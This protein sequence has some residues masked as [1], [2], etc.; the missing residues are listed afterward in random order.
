MSLGAQSVTL[1]QGGSIGRVGATI[2]RTGTAGS[3]TLSVNGLP[4]GASATFVQPG[5]GSSGTIALNPGTAAA[6]TY[7]LTVQASDGTYSGSASL[8]LILN[9]G[10]A[11]QLPGPFAW[12]STGPLISEISDATHSLVSVKDPTV[13]YY[14]NRWHVYATTADSAGNW[15]ME[16][17]NFTDWSQAAAA[18]PYYIDANPGLR[19]YHC[20]PEVFYFTPQSKWYLIYQSQQPQYSTADDLSQPGT[21]TA[22]QNFFA[23][24]PATVN[25]WID[26]WMICDST[27][28][29][30]FFSGDDGRWYRSQTS[31]ANFPNGF[32][33]PLVI[34]E[35]ANRADL[36]EASNVYYLKGLN[37]YLAIIEC[38]G[39]TSGQRYFRAFI[40]DRLDGDWTP[41]A[42]ANSWATPFAGINNVSFDSG[43]SAWTTDISHGEMLRDGYDQTL[44]IDPAN[45]QFLY[46]GVNPAA[47]GQ[48]YA[49]LPWQLGII[50][51]VTGA[52]AH[53]SHGLPVPPGGGVPKPSGAAGG[54]KVLDW[55]GFKAAVTYTYDDALPSQIAAYPQ[56]QA[57]GARMTFFLTCG[58]D[59]N[60]P[61]WTQAA[62][63][64]HELGNHTVHHCH[65]DGTGCANYA[66]SLEAEYDLCTDHIKQTYGVSNVWTTAAPFGDTGYDAVAA[67]RF[68]LNRGVWGGQVAPNDNSDPYNLPIHGV[69]EGETAGAFNSYID[70]ARAAGHWLIFMFHSLGGDG[71]YAPVNA[72]D[73]IASI[74]HAKAPGDIWVDSMVNVGAY[75][76]GQ[77]AVSSAVS[78]QSGSDTIV[79][80]SLPAHFPAGKY[81]RVS[82]TGG[83]VKQGGAAL[84]WHDGGYYEVALDDGSL[85]VGP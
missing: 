38:M 11:P 50:R 49:K 24:K 14:A 60:S 71:G 55:A 1:P 9:A 70:S 84:P 18:Q 59:G 45:L 40:S 21:W 28:C 23:A 3:V 56:L 34:M 10:L 51:R 62:K 58:S 61:M 26:Y 80:W 78:V 77:K 37:Q 20:A 43:V 22:P 33:E 83:T 73:V 32:S 41:L 85:T 52:A 75:W 48:D 72:A 30:M 17:V 13:V 46:Q 57:T 69:P 68:F 6:G 64:G 39:G 15:S 7:S 29:Y 25:D 2:S 54:L 74:H 19:G 79:T 67:T 66:G 16:Y 35:A 27:N 76:A 12:S 81:V 36:F 47:R 8:S 63:D 5:S 31:V 82:V 65:A 44:T 4:A 53:E 42:S